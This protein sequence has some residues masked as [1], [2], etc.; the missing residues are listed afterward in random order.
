[1]GYEHE[2]WS[3]SYGYGD[4]ETICRGHWEMHHAAVKR[5]IEADKSAGGRVFGDDSNMENDDAT[6]SE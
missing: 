5:G 2:N 3:G 4:G 1:M 6:P